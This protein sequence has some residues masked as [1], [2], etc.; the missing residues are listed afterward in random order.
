MLRRRFSEKGD[1]ATP[2][3][4]SATPSSSFS[5]TVFKKLVATIRHASSLI[6]FS[7]AYC[8]TCARL[9]PMAFAVCS[10]VKVSVKH[11]LLN[12]AVREE[13]GEVVIQER[14]PIFRFG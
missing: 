10:W 9:H 4:L 11:K 1:F 2:V 7:M 3:A 8:E 14:L 5:A 6:L 12:F 13:Q